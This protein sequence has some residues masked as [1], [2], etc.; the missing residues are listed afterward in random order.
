M[1]AAF[2]IAIASVFSL[3]GPACADQAAIMDALRNLAVERGITAR[4]VGECEHH[5]APGEADAYVAQLAHTSGNPEIAKL[6]DG[7]R[8]VLL[9]VYAEGRKSGPTSE[10]TAESCQRL[11]D[12]QGDLLEAANRHLTEVA[13]TPTDSVE[14]VPSS[15]PASSASK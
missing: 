7:V 8:D 1:R 11:I 13:A 3:S 2:F 4:I 9:R 10:L 14:P 15:I 12:Q 5:M 6:E